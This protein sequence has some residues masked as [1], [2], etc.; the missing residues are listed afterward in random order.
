M[1][2]KLLGILVLW[3][4]LSTSSMAQVRLSFHQL[5]AKLKDKATLIVLGRYQRFRGPCYPMRMKGGKMGRRWSMY[6]GFSVKKIAKGKMKLPLVNLSEYDLPANQ[7]HIFRKFKTFEYYWLLLRPSE[8]TQE[9]LNKDYIVLRHKVS[10]A[11]VVGIYPA[12]KE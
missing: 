7:A 1:K 12:K 6:F 2:T 3:L 8:R 10:A 4:L 11:E 5:P 9:M